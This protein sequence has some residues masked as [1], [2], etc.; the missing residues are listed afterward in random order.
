MLKTKKTYYKV[1]LLEQEEQ[2]KQV[3]IGAKGVT[4]EKLLKWQI[5]KYIEGYMQIKIKRQ[6]NKKSDI[7]T[8]IIALTSD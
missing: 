6:G 1:L 3:I 8:L 5:V 7:I 2:A 4:I